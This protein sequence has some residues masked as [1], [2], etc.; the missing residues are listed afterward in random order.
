LK[1]PAKRN[2]YMKV[3]KGI[4]ESRMIELVKYNLKK[5]KALAVYP[6]RIKGFS[7]AKRKLNWLNKK[8]TVEEKESGVIWYCRPE[9]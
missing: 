4:L 1:R 2:G 5:K 7:K 3:E 6:E 9:E 8:L